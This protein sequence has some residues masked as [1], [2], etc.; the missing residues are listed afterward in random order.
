MT[1][2]GTQAFLSLTC[3]RPCSVLVDT[4]N[5]LEMDVVLRSRMLDGAAFR[6]TTSPADPSGSS[7]TSPSTMSLEPTANT[8]ERIHGPCERDVY[9]LCFVNTGGFLPVAL[10]LVHGTRGR[11]I[12]R[13]HFDSSCG[14]CPRAVTKGGNSGVAAYACYTKC[15]SRR[16]SKLSQRGMN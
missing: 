15:G 11:G 8:Y 4:T 14:S 7:P 12:D 16:G 10:R 3:S 6:R 5:G 13:Q 9:T 1:A 2:K